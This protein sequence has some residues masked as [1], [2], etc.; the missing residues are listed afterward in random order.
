ME[1]VPAE[2]VRSW[3]DAEDDLGIEVE[4]LATAI[5]VRDFGSPDGMLCAI[6]DTSEGQAELRRQAEALSAGCSVLGRSFLKYDRALFV[7]TLNDWGW[8]GARPAP[9]WYSGEPWTS[10]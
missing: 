1:D 8:C 4:L 5:L 6:R 3:V 10:P 7:D 2:L 9:P